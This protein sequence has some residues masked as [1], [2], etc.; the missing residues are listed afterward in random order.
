MVEP[1]PVLTDTPLLI[2]EK[3]KKERSFDTP[4]LDK[5]RGRG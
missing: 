3:G 2:K 5:E 1:H 4:L